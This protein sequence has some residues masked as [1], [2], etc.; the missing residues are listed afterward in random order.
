MD[1]KVNHPGTGVVTIT[2]KN[3]RT[4]E[5]REQFFVVAAGTTVDNAVATTIP[6]IPGLQGLRNSGIDVPNNAS[7]HTDNPD[8]AGADVFGGR[9][10][11]YGGK[12]GSTAVYVTWK[13]DKGVL[14]T[15]VVIVTVEKEKPATAPPTPKRTTPDEGG[16]KD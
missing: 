16:N 3:A 4:G 15:S 2:W 5:Q 11:L 7:V 13:D 9:L 8:V 6:R 14:H 1:Y 10:I 12:E